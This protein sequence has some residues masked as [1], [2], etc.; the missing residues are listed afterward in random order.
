MS[1]TTTESTESLTADS[2]SAVGTASAENPQNKPSIDTLNQEADAALEEATQYANQARDAGDAGPDAK[3]VERRSLT[4]EERRE[5][6]RKTAKK[7]SQL[8]LAELTKVYKSTIVIMQK[9]AV[10]DTNI[11]SS[12]QR[13]LGLVDRTFYLLNRYGN[14]YQTQAEVD[15][16]REIL[17]DLVDTYCHEGAAAVAQAK[18]LADEAKLKVVDWLEPT[19]TTKTLD[20]EFGVKS[21]DTV[22][23]IKGV[24]VWDQAILDFAALEF[25]D[26]ASIGQIDTMRQR[27]R[28]LFMALN[29]MCLR[30]IGG[31]SKRR[32][33]MAQA[34]AK[35]SKNEGDATGDAA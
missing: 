25:N 2:T 11:A 15:K 34:K 27:E 4:A 30:T 35:P 17:R 14:L 31:I 7:Q 10:S 8:G 3:G 6:A 32:N 21:S 28:R 23:L 12:A 22:R 33:R 18:L 1:D 19:Y 5:L 24:Q 26:T 29:I 16:V 20:V 9:I 13:F